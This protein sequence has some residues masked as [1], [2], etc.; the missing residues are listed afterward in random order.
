MDKTFELPKWWDD[1][2]KVKEYI[3]MIFNENLKEFNNK[4]L[5]RI[6]RTIRFKEQIEKN[7]KNN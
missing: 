3:M 5:L 2:K 1:E 7:N 6:R 4:E